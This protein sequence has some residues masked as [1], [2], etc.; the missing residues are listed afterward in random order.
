MLFI[1]W[2]AII[3]WKSRAPSAMTVGI[4]ATADEY[5]ARVSYPIVD[6]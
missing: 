2:P 4:A 1:A 6:A 3:A 5:V